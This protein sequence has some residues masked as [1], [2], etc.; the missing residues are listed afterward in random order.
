MKE[1]LRQAEEFGYSWGEVVG[2]DKFVRGSV[3]QAVGFKTKILSI[4]RLLLEP[5]GV[6]LQGTLAVENEGGRCGADDV[7]EI[8]SAPYN[9]LTQHLEYLGVAAV[10][11]RG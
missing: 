2:A 4:L 8:T 6:T 1:G 10:V 11:A 9:V 3:K 7:V 5:L